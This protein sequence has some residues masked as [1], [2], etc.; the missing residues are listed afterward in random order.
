ME[1]LAVIASHSTRT[2]DVTNV[3]AI[4][5]QVAQLLSTAA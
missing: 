5:P 2:I 1:E 3:L 4:S